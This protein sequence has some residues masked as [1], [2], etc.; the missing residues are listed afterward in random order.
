MTITIYTTGRPSKIF[1]RED[2][3]APFEY[4]LMI[5]GLS[6]SDDIEQQEDPR[7]GGLVVI[8]KGTTATRRAIEAI[9]KLAWVADVTAPMSAIRGE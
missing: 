4:D 3:V 8:L 7:W 9:K 1:D 2:G 6:E 5:D